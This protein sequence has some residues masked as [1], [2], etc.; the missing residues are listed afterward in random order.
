MI[1]LS[2]LIAPEAVVTDLE[3][4]DA[5]G[6]TAELL[7]KLVASGGVAADDEQAV[8]DTLA[9]R[10]KQGSTGFGKGVAVPHAKHPAVREMTAAFGRS[11][12]GV[13]FNSHDGRP[14][15]LVVLLLSPVERSREHLDAMQT[16]SKALNR[17]LFRRDLREAT[18]RE[19]I[20]ALFREADG[21]A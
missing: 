7:A 4:G 19:G 14:V 1:R 12:K 5:R 21:L 10:E 8:L 17:D 3:A 13:E 6:V 18:Q 16:L 11:D 15:H 9:A 20:L 2:D